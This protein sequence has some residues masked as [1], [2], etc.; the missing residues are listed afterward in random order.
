MNIWKTRFP[1]VVSALLFFLLVTGVASSSLLPLNPSQY[2]YFFDDHQ[3][4]ESKTS[5]DQSLRFLR[6]LPASTCYTLAGTSFPVQ[7]LIDSILYFQK[8]L[9]SAPTPEKLNQQIQRFFIV[10]RM[11]TLLGSRS[12]RALITGYYQPV[13][14][15]SRERRPPYLYP[16]YAV[17]GSLVVKKS[18]SQK[19]TIGRM[20]DGKMLPFWTRREIESDNVLQGQELVWLK[21]PFDVFVLHIQGSGIIQLTDG[22]VGGVHYAQSNGRAYRSIG[23]YMVDSGRM[24]L[25]DVN[26]DSIRLYLSIHPE[27][28]NSILHKNDAFIFFNWSKAGPVIGNLG[29]ELTAG[30][31]IAADQQWYPPGALV[32]LDSRKPKVKNGEIIDWERL[33]RFVS[34]QDTGSAIIGPN[35]VDIFLGTGEEAG[36]VAG[37]MKEDGKVYL[38]ILKEGIK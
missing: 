26:M 23:K 6:A 29:Q 24:N 33:R 36:L 16:L 25:A 32:F 12:R 34:V 5:L 21:D 18:G 4:R 9:L 22:T 28:R 31:S 1:A 17:P 19:K 20:Q 3:L 14:A 15:G 2:P 38:L 27:E 35:R 8:L 13:F 10:Y 30:R 7:R 11:D 37:R